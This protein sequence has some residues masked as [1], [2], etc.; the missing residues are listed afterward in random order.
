MK[1]LTRLRGP[2]SVPSV[3]SFVIVFCLFLFVSTSIK[4]NNTLCL[5]FLIDFHDF[6]IKANYF[7]SADPFGVFGVFEATVLPSRYPA[8]DVPS[9]SEHYVILSYIFLLYLI[10][11]FTLSYPIV[12]INKN[13]QI[14]P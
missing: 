8:L 12:F 11:S 7:K 9:R 4:L 6:L 14:S 3:A 5:G 2:P 1:K 10:L 13:I